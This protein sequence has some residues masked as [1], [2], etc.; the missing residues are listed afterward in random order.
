M[1]SEGM[2]QPLPGDQGFNYSFFTYNNAEPS[3]EDPVN[4]FRN[5][6]EVGP[7]EGFACQ[8]VVDEAL[9]WLDSVATGRDP[10]Y[11]NVWFNEPHVRLAAPD[12]L[13]ARHGYN[14]VYYGAIEN[15]DLAIGRL[16]NYLEEHGLSEN[17]I[18]LFTSDNG[19]QV[20]HSNYPFRGSKVFNYE[21]GIRVPFIIRWDQHIPS[22]RVSEF[23]GSFTDILPSLASMT[24]ITPPQDRVLDGINLSPVFLG[25]EMAE[26]RED[27]IYF[28]RYF[29]DPICMLREGDWV[30]LGYDELI[31]YQEQLNTR[32]LAKIKPEPDKPQWSE[33]GFKENHMEVTL[34]QQPN[35]FELYNLKS[36]IGQKNNLAEDYPDR[37][38]EMRGRMLKFKEEMISEGDNWYK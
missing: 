24:D 15:M 38:E 18:I 32:D 35:Y 33:W 30:L 2:S 17:T 25:Q 7:M 6:A 22:G 1:T 34:E 3:H 13:K 16:L 8:L 21:G 10:F 23:T 28:Y 36:D 27:P 5:S 19:S 29:H 12:S 31:P 26:Q 11:I 4:F 37:V 14:E 20:H 9:G